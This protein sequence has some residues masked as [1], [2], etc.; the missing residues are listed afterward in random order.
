MNYFNTKNLCRIIKCENSPEL[1]N[2][3]GFTLSPCDVGI[4]EI[5]DLSLTTE[6]VKKL[7]EEQKIS[8]PSSSFNALLWF[9]Y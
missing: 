4:C 2:F 3:D 7:G 5:N 9:L 6:T 1:G 8:F